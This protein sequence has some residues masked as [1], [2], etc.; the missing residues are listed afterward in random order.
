[1]IRHR[2]NS[3]QMGTRR[4]HIQS[5]CRSCAFI[6]SHYQTALHTKHE[7][8]LQS[9]RQQLDLNLSKVLLPQK[10]PTLE[11]Y[12]THAKLAV[13][14]GTGRHRFAIGLFSPGTHRVVEAV[15]CP[16]HTSEMNQLLKA[17]V[18][19]LERSTLS[20]YDEKA[21]KGDIRYLTIRASHSTGRM[22]VTFVANSSAPRTTLKE[23]VKR[24]RA[25]GFPIHS[26]YL[27]IHSGSGNQI[28][29]ESTLPLT[30]SENLREELAGLQF[31]IGPTTF[32]QVN[33]AQAENIYRRIEQ[34]VGY[35]QEGSIAWDLYCGIAPITM[36][37]TRAGFRVLGIEENPA[38]IKFGNSN[39]RANQLSH[40]V[41][42]RAGRVEDTIDKLPTWAAKPSLIVANP[43]RRGMA[44]DV[45]SRLGQIATTRNQP[46]SLIYVS[47]DVETLARDLADL[48]QR[49]FKL[50]Q[51][52][53][54]DMFCHTD[55]LEWLAV[56]TT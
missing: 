33:P 3:T 4:C 43:S 54:F 8:G 47:C 22:M 34:L 9:L 14:R 12:R 6:N 42:L 2:I 48:T 39:L 51:V 46:L 5:E 27:N 10:A 18:A 41:E 19:E 29:G 16:L 11:A 21:G 35:S 13:R 45:R 31:A 1:M 44:E 56:L 32:F 15:N 17:I 26:A 36:L 24:L 38:S 25:F 49:G 55:K 20:P 30:G 52:E 23:I 7:S 40:N 50:R 28:F 53:S 37:L